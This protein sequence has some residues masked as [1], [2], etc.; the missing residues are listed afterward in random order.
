MERFYKL[1]CYTFILKSESLS[2]KLSEIQKNIEKIS[3]ENWNKSFGGTASSEIA[4]KIEIDN[5]I[6]MRAMEDLVAANY[7]TI[8]ANVE[9]SQI[10]I[11][12]E[13]REFEFTPIK[14]HIYIFL[15]SRC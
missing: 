3:I 8:N 9:L 7:G 2:L 11:D 13:T 15:Q 14:V 4:N 1:I 10:S 6:V 12:S 5:S